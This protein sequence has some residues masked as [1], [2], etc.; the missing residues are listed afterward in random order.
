LLALPVS[1]DA[2]GRTYAQMIAAKLAEKAIA[3]DIAAAR[4]L[5][6]RAEGKPRQSLEI[7]CAAFRNAFERMNETELR[8][9][10]ETGALPAWFPQTER[11]NETAE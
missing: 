5:A 4:E 11:E 3:G 1:G 8:A 10:A 6:D 2:E 7:E 9:Y